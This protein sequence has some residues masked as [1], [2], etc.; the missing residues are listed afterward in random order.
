MSIPSK[1]YCGF[2]SDYCK[3]NSILIYQLNLTIM[4]KPGILK[5]VCFEQAGKASKFV[6]FDQQAYF[7]TKD[8]GSGEGGIKGGGTQHLLS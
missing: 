2:I 3:Y 6:C 4:M 1:Y 8:T 7:D 5:F